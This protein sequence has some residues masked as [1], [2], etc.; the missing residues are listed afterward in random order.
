MR[1]VWQWCE[2]SIGSWDPRGVWLFASRKIQRK[3]G[4]SSNLVA[5]MLLG[6][7]LDVRHYAAEVVAF[8]CLERRELLER[9][10]VLQPQH[11]AD[12][13]HIPVVL[14]GSYRTSERPAKAHSGLL[15]NADRLL[16]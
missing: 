3:N 2:V 15:V 14:E 13:Q 8:S 6:G 16:E 11:L 5:R 4:F 10:Q 12:R 7:F 9:L 1:P